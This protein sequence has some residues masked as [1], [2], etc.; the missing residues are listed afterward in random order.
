M[1]LLKADSLAEDYK[2][3]LKAMQPWWDPLDEYER[4]ARN[5]PHSKVVAAKMPTVTDGTLSGVIRSQP[6]RVVQQI[7][8][9]RN[10]CQEYP[11]LAPLV[12]YIVENEIIPNADYN[13]DVITKSWLMISRAA[14]YG[15]SVSY[16]FFKNSGDYFGGDFS[17][18]YIKDIIF[19][20][21]KSYGP[22]CKKLYMRQWYTED[23]INTI[24]ER[25]SRLKRNA[26]KR[27]ENYEGYWD[28][29][30]LRKA[31]KTVK[32][33]NQDALS[34]AEKD[35]G[36]A[37]EA[38]YVQIVHAFEEGVG[39][40]FYSFAVDLEDGQN[41]ARKKDNP[42]PTGK[43]P[44]SFMY[45]DI[46]LSNPLGVGYV[47]MSG[48]LQNLL[49]SEVQT[50]QLMQKLM[51]AP[52]VMKWGKGIKGSTI[53]W[54]T[55]AVWDMGNDPNAKIEAVNINNQAI[56]NFVNNY[57]LIKSQILNLTN[58]QDASVGTQSAGPNNQ[59][60]TPAGIAQQNA[61]LG[62]DDNFVRKRF[63]AWFQDN[64]ERVTNIHFAESD[65]SREIE[66]TE[67]W[68][69]DVYQPLLDAANPQTKQL[70]QQQQAASQNGQEPPQ[71]D[72]KEQILNDLDLNPL[73][74]K[75]DV[76]V[77]K[78][79]ATVLYGEI[80]TKFKF[81]VD[82]T[83]SEATDDAD[84]VQHLKDLI[85]DVTANPQA[86]YYLMNDGWQLHLG[87]AYRD[88][89]MRLGVANISK[90]L[91]RLPKEQRAAA[92]N[93]PLSPFFDKPSIRIDYRDI[94]D[95]SARAAVLQNAGISG[96]HPET[97]APTSP[98]ILESAVRG[99]KQPLPPSDVPGL[100]PPDQGGD[101]QAGAAV[102]TPSAPAQAPQP[103][104]GPEQA[105]PSPTGSTPV[106]APGD[107]QLATEFLRNG[108]SSRQA[109]AA[110]VLMHRRYN[111]EQ[112]MAAVG[113]PQGQGGQ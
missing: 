71:Q 43:M 22:D 103:G 61:K 32:K 66:L 55:N 40:T 69:E 112:I 30:V 16:A 1:P 102:P 8:T 60:K 25:E 29:S 41:V 75:F 76:D 52:P 53:K 48:A 28:V 111:H 51:L 50:Y 85:T 21:G 74:E 67:D 91:T 14:T 10:T 44:L 72:P 86:M 12:D 92:Q 100:S 49:D 15:C 5:K 11:E 33:K 27:K 90:I 79:V 87:E 78:Q 109:L 56:S 31:L 104:P 35:A 77:E 113:Q 34:P 20:K 37:P 106:L 23:D 88:L 2:D 94:E 58:N 36:K 83:S 26:K 17:L 47:E 65:G 110:V 108:Y 98:A 82:P 99:D 59:S 64:M 46:D 18:P 63:E 62:F 13:G 54:K 4:I 45:M 93:G 105:P 81:R 42:D 3:A 9:G 101:A 96:Q 107:R 38:D 84:Q 7:P 95:P 97:M 24:I 57:S 80:K 6:K 68:L 19:Q 39:A 89:I 70:L 73:S